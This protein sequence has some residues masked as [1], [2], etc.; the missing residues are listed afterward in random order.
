MA[1]R[2]RVTKKETKKKEPEFEVM[3]KEEPKFFK[4]PSKI[5]KEHFLE[6]RLNH[7]MMENLNKDFNAINLR[8]QNLEKDVKL[9]LLKKDDIR[10][11]TDKMK[12]DHLLLLQRIEK[13]TGVSVVNKEI[14]PETLEVY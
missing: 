3:D 10:R 14:D 8:I 4:N 7:L 11:A 12:N 13:E 9:A 1:R 5:T 6:I 2:K